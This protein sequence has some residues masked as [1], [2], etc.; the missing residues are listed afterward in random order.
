M[1]ALRQIQSADHEPMVN[2][3]GYFDDGHWTVV[4]F[5]RA[6][7][8]PACYFA[9]APDQLTVSPAILEMCGIL[10]TTELDHFARLDA[11]MAR[12]IY[13]EVSIASGQFHQV[14]AQLTQ[15]EAP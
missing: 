12:A 11:A 5:P 14:L 8:R 9:H 2:L 15:A 4:L 1:T 6:V 3:L 13:A 10:V 7:H